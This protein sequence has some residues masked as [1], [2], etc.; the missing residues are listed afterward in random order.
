MANFTLA[1]KILIYIYLFGKFLRLNVRKAVIVLQHGI[2]VCDNVTNRTQPASIDIIYVLYNSLLL[3][4]HL[5]YTFKTKY[6]L[7]FTCTCFGI[8]TF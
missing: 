1:T 4:L 2:Y 6:S 7:Q 8:F 5:I 3:L